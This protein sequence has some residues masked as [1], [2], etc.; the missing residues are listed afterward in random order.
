MKFFDT[1]VRSTFFLASL[2]LMQLAAFAQSNPNSVYSRFG[3]GIIDNPGN[4]NHFGMGGMTAAQSDPICLNLANPA[5]YAFLDA[6]NL[7]TTVKG[8]HTT[9]NDG[10]ATSK[11]GNGQIHELSMGFRKPTG[12]WGI[13]I[14][15]SPYSSVDYRFTSK[16]TLS[17]TLTATYRYNGRGGLNKAT[18]GTSRVFRF[19]SLFSSDSLKQRSD[20]NQVKLHQLSVGINANYIFGNITRENYV[21][22][23]QS[24]HY[25]TINYVNLWTKGISLETGIQYKVNLTTRRDPQ[26]RIIGGSALQLGAV[27][28]MES[29]LGVEYTELISSLRI[30]GT[31]ALRDTSYFLDAVGGRLIIPQRIQAGL[32]YKIYNKKWG[33]LMLGA[34]FKLQDWSL[35]RLSISEDANLDEGL[36][37]AQGWSVGAEFK[38]TTDVSNN[39]FNRLQ[40]RVGYRAYQS[41]LVL[42]DIRIE[43]TGITAGLSI[44]VIRSQSKLN[45]GVEIGQRGT[46][47]QGLISE[48]YVAFMVGFSLSPSSFDRWFRQVK[49]D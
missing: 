45:L 5:S 35:Y 44:P 30:A 13:A 43:Q 31:S 46:L 27:Y 33:A 28:A 16:D 9:T 10:T 42:N 36:Q 15:L 29:N 12:K 17:D 14:G 37:S 3:L 48:D 24:E 26:R 6:T 8:A 49:Y 22:F 2:L 41:E 1:T 18:I 21:S 39:F 40:Y 11:Y 32:A 20:S 34:E 4:A 38:P 47:D 19:G 7:Q 25:S 23:D